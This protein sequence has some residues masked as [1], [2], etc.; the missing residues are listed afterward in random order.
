MPLWSDQV[1]IL[2]LVG[3][4]VV[5][6]TNVSLNYYHKDAKMKRPFQL[7]KLITKIKLDKT[8]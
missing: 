6:K 3:R 4:C 2:T 8:T 1:E 5:Y 7:V